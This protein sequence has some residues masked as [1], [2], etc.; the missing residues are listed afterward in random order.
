MEVSFCNTL[1]ISDISANNDTLRLFSEKNIY[2][3]GVKGGVNLR[4][5]IV[6]ISLIPFFR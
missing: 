1:C 6:A 5:K 3:R 2:A 4:K